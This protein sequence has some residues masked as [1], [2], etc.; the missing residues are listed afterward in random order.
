V[1]A[2]GTGLA[3]LFIV[4]PNQINFVIS[5]SDSLIYLSIEQ[6]GS[7]YI[8]KGMVIPVQSAQPGFF[9]LNKAGLAAAS[10][11]RIAANGT[12]TQVPA[13]ACTNSGCT[14]IPIDAT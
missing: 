1:T 5:G 6:I 4:S 12:V 7:P 8:P 10:A 3:P 2:Y 13:A 14:A 11:V 9:S